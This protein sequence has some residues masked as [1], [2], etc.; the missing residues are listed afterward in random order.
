MD[1]DPVPTAIRDFKR[2]QRLGPNAACAWCGID[3]LVVLRAVP[4]GSELDQW[5]R[6]R[7]HEMHHPC[8]RAHDP[9][10]TICLCFNCHAIAT[11]SQLR[12][13]VPL[14][15]QKNPLD[16]VIARG[17]VLATFHRGSGDA[18]DRVAEGMESFRTFLDRT[19]DEWREQWEKYK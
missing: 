6:V 11:E 7:L 19:Y 16:R 12:E 4:K 10:L 8:G 14:A 3:D 2:E 1:R 5:I 9:K 17:R 18:E 15:P 13:V